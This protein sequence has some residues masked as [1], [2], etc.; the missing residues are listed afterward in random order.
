MLDFDENVPEL[1]KRQR[2]AIDNC[3]SDKEVMTLGSNC[4]VKKKGK[5]GVAAAAFQESAHVAYRE[6]VSRVKHC[7][8]RQL[9]PLDPGSAAV[10]VKLPG[11]DGAPPPSPP[12]L[13]RLT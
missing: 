13:Y 1:T 4:T 7:L 9:Q 5:S 12:C 8:R 6:V 11:S 3:Y 2:S 10:Q